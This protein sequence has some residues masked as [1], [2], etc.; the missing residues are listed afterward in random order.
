MEHPFVDPA[1]FADKSIEDMEKVIADLYSKARYIQSRGDPHMQQQL[2]MLIESHKNI[3]QAKIDAKF[4]NRGSE[5]YNT[6]I[7]ISS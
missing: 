1:A 7:D 5:D 3:L 2:W 4:G 6:T